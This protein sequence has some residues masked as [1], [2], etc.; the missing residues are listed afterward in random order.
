MVV[1]A[2]AGLLVW[3]F[4]VDGF[5][6]QTYTSSYSKADLV[7]RRGYSLSSARIPEKVSPSENELINSEGDAPIPLDVIGAQEIVLL[8]NPQEPKPVYTPASLARAS[9]E[10]LWQFMSDKRMSETVLKSAIRSNKTDI[11]AYFENHRKYLT[12]EEADILQKNADFFHAINS[13]DLELLASVLLDSNETLCM[14]AGQENI[15]SGY[16]NVLKYWGAYFA[17]QRTITTH[18]TSLVFQGDLAV[19]TSVMD[20][21][22]LPQKETKKKAKKAKIM[23]SA[24]GFR[25]R[26]VQ[27]GNLAQKGGKTGK[28]DDDSKL[29]S[30]LV[31]NIFVRPYGSDGYNLLLHYATILPSVGAKQLE[32]RDMYRAPMPPKPKR[33]RSPFGAMLRGLNVFEGDDEEVEDEGDEEEGDEEEGGDE[34]GADGDQIDRLAKALSGL[35]G[36]AGGPRKIVVVDGAGGQ[37]PDWSK[38]EKLIGEAA[39]EEGGG[40]KSDAA[41]FAT[42]L[43]KFGK[44]EIIID[45][46]KGGGGDGEEFF[47]EDEEEQNEKLA[48]ELASKTLAI[49]RYLHAEGRLTLNEKR[50]LTHDLISKAGGEDFSQVEVAMSLLIG[51]GRPL[52]PSWLDERPEQTALR[53]LP[54]SYGSKSSTYFD[55]NVQEEQG[56][57]N[58]VISNLNEDDLDE[59]E[60]ICHIIAANLVELL[61]D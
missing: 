29:Q 23:T 43:A 26:T 52:E 8:T 20:I 49:I 27:G 14:R 46:I 12:L 9:P 54:Y 57:Q 22:P 10:E 47:G 45:D 21:H 4:A 38:I 7:Y 11:S 41:N 53:K 5:R 34:E 59:F 6:P 28:K 40:D 56:M 32:M 55:I 15:I 35:G 2:A 18:N 61:D 1:R 39:S 24:N 31:T 36:R 13:T 33:S 19:V 16:E 3:L 58:I 50:L 30:A 17:E 25:F 48:K 51:G 44:G 60:N 42:S 37:P